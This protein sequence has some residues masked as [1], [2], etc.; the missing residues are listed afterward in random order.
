MRRLS[1]ELI[2]ALR[3]SFEAWPDVAGK[4][5]RLRTASNYIFG[6]VCPKEGNGAS[7]DP[8]RLQYQGNKYPH[9]VEI[10]QTVA[11]GPALQSSVHRKHSRRI[12]GYQNAQQHHR[13]I[14][15]PIQ[16]LDSS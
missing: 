12:A 10:A 5:G 3:L 15:M 16:S 7:L 4:I 2:S 13:M 1:R 14:R 11:I 6:A 8:G 9:L